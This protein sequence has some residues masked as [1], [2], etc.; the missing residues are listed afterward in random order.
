M[1]AHRPAK[2]ALYLMVK[3]IMALKLGCVLFSR[4]PRKG[5]LRW[6]HTHRPAKHAL[7]L[8]VKTK[9]ALVRAFQPRAAQG[10]PARH[11]KHS[12]AS[13][14][15]CTRMKRQSASDVHAPRGEARPV[16]D[17]QKSKYPGRNWM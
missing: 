10:L 13:P 6:M 4:A 2:H 7:Y 12:S 17:A 8:M 15:G 14:H 16:A 5:S 11:V 9:V 1:H 3:T